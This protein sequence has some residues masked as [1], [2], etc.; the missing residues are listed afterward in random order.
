MTKQFLFYIGPSYLKGLCKESDTSR[1]IMILS[2]QQVNEEHNDHKDV[3]SWIAGVKEYILEMNDELIKSKK[4]IF[5]MDSQIFRT[6]TN[7]K[8][9]I[10]VMV[11]IFGHD[12]PQPFKYRM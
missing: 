8:R 5:F 9:A 4:L 6:H 3:D 2:N 7:P 11:N 12:H 1:E 10:S